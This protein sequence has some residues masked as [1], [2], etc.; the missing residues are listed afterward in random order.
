ME[1]MP[2]DFERALFVAAHPDDIEYGLAAVAARWTSQGKEVVYV[3]ATS[4]EAGIDTIPP[5]ESGPL[6]EAEELAGAAEVGVTTVDFL[7][8]PDGI[9]E[10]TLDLRRALARAIRRHRPDVVACSGL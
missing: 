9:V 8:F 6:R 7:G 10:P 2:E 3:L 5:A 4:G 1:P